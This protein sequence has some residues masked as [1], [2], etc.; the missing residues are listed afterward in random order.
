MPKISLRQCIG[1]GGDVCWY[2]LVITNVEQND[3]GL[4]LCTDHGEPPNNPL[5]TVR[6]RITGWINIP[7]IMI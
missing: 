1:G 2:M 3:T 4:Y 5:R 6:L 7:Q